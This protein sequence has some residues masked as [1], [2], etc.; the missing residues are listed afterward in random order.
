MSDLIPTTPLPTLH[1]IQVT[2]LPERDDPAEAYLRRLAV[3]SR[4]TMIDSLNVLAA[5]LGV[6]EVREYVTDAQHVPRTLPNGQPHTTNVSYRYCRWWALRGQDTGLL[7]EAL[8]QRYPLT[9]ANKMLSALRGVLKQ[10]HRQQLLPT[11][12]YLR[13]VDVENI[14][15]Q[16]A[17][18]GQMLER[19]DL[20]QL[21]SR[22]TADQRATAVRDLAILALMAA[23]GP[24]RNEV[25]LL[26]Y[27]DYDPLSRRLRL[28]GKGNKERDVYLDHIS[29]AV[30]LDWRNLRGDRP[31]PLFLAIK[32]GNHLV[33][34]QP[35]SYHAIYYIV[36]RRGREAGLRAFS[37]H[38][39]RR[40]A[41]SNLLDTSDDLFA[42]SE[43]AGHSDP[44]TTKKYDRRGERAKQRVAATVDLPLRRWQP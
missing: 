38:D 30:L 21:L 2:R 19:P 7:R 35:L 34:D 31:G 39:L 40:T 27:A 24:R 10:C 29:A 13:A 14:K 32:K 1:V 8:A 16:R 23:L 5:L 42:V 37:P 11:E 36:Q 6:P 43:V 12:D 25:R 28:R 15:G 20:Q 4:P 41:I 26:Q 3:G 33:Y 9:T 22:I 44:K 18:R 17:L